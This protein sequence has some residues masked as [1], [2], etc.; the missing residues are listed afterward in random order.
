MAVL[1]TSLSPLSKENNK[2]AGVKYL[3]FDISIQSLC[4]NSTHS[5]LTIEFFHQRIIFWKAVSKIKMNL[6]E[7]VVVAGIGLNWP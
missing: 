3:L 1:V 2:V 7:I 6:K 4:N 5:V